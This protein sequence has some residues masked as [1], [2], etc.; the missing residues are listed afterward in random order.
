MLLI[1]SGAVAAVILLV[2]L[3]LLTT[4][5]PPKSA[6]T[7]GTAT[8]VARQHS[9]TSHDGPTSAS[10]PPPTL[11]PSV[12]PS[13]VAPGNTTSTVASPGAG[14]IWQVTQSFHGASLG[15]NGVS[16]PSATVC[17][18]VGE[19]TLVT[20]MALRSTD[21][22][23]TWVQQSV[24][25]V[26]APLTAVD[27]PSVSTCFALGATSLL[28]TTD[29]GATWKVRTLGNDHLAALSCRSDRV[30]MAAGQAQSSNST[31]ATG[32]TYATT[33][34]GVSWTTSLVHCF[35]PTGISCSTATLCELA[36]A[37][38]MG[39]TAFG[40]IYG[41]SNGGFGWPRQYL[42]SAHG[43]VVTAV[44][45]PT[46]NQCHAVGNAGI[47][48]DLRTINGGRRWFA[49]SVPA[50]AWPRYYVAV[51]CFST[52]ICQATGNAPPIVTENAGENW[53]LQTM[54]PQVETMTG[55]SCPTARLCVGVA[56]SL[57]SGAETLTLV[58]PAPAPS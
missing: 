26:D 17:E 36:G 22:G 52:L 33:N 24:P 3:I 28:K 41:T 54:A 42:N 56:T 48:S 31:C 58:Q 11:P 47:N 35:V 55:V 1:G 37:Q 23:A 18:A 16:C 51:N 2:I 49:Q 30:C 32:A 29:G 34:G 6:V 8:T 39:T 45:C 53:S 46:V 40:A 15:L 14:T 50:S 19:T 7:A 4:S 38:Q 44:T 5:S 21:A 25:P 27:C 13:T 43:S 57:T 9:G 20:D 12:S 10:Q